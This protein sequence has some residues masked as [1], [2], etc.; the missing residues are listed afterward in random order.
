[1]QYDGKV[2]GHLLELLARE[3]GTVGLEPASASRPSVET[4]SPNSSLSDFWVL[5]EGLLDAVGIG[6]SRQNFQSR[7]LAHRVDRGEV[8]DVEHRDLERVV[9]LLIRDDVV[10]ARDGLGI[11]EDLGRKCSPV[12]LAKGM[13]RRTPGCGG[14]R[15]RSGCLVRQECRERLPS[16][17]RFEVGRRQMSFFATRPESIMNSFSSPSRRA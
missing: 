9:A 16:L 17:L 3:L 6:Q 11:A 10:G 15:R 14:E 1:M 12:R 13:P 5:Q 2:L 7:L 4:M 8:L